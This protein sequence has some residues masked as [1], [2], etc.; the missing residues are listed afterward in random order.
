VTIEAVATGDDLQY[1][2]LANGKPVT[3]G[4]HVSGATTPLLKL[5]ALTE[6]DSAE[7]TCR[8]T[9]TC[10]EAISTSALVTAATGPVFAQQ[11]QSAQVC[12][13]S[14]VTLTSKA[15][16]EGAVTYQWE[17]DGVPLADAPQKV[18]G[19]QQP[20]LTISEVGAG[21]LGDYRLRAT[22][23]C[24]TTLS[25]IAVLTLRDWDAV[26]PLPAAGDLDK[27]VPVALPYDEDW[28]LQASLKGCSAGHFKRYLKGHETE[29]LDLFVHAGHKK[30]GLRLANTKIWF[31]S[32]LV[33]EGH[34]Y[35]EWTKDHYAYTTHDLPVS[36]GD[37]TVR[38]EYRVG[39]GDD[40]GNARMYWDGVLV[41]H[42]TFWREKLPPAMTFLRVGHIQGGSLKYLVGCVDLGA[43]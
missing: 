11:P 4:P 42:W 27:Q 21:D 5:S 26:V 6:A 25:D 13:H 34:F 31:L 35:P 41:G 7:Y 30:L 36:A 18:T 8:V 38:I 17:K 29:F 37:H 20:A 33:G 3:D 32:A 19:S 15:Q 43:E 39:P 1:Q 22:D 16:G 40:D 23:G 9:G 14:T 12:E 10:G 28:V 24:G 2:W